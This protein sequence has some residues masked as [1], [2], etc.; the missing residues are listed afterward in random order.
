MRAAFVTL[1]ALAGAPPA[2]AAPDFDITPD[3]REERAERGEDFS[4]EIR[5]RECAKEGVQVQVLGSGGP[6]LD[7]GQA[8]SGHLVW[9][10][11]RARILVDLGGGVPV[12]YEEAGAVLRDLDAFVF[13][14]L[15]ADH[16]AG[17]P[18][19]VKGARFEER[20]DDLP[21][22]G[23]TGNQLFPGT[24]DWVNR[25][26]GARGAYPYLSDFLTSLSSAGFKIAP[27]D[28]PAEGRRIWS[29]HYAGGSKLSAV[30]VHHGPV[31]A[32]AWRVDTRTVSVTFTGDAN[33]QKGTIARLADGSDILVAHHAIPEQARGTAREL[34]MRPSQIG[35]IAQQAGV[36]MV[37]LSHRMSRTRG[38]ESQTR[39]AIA[40]HFGGPVVFGDDLECWGL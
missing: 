6:E 22:Y 28:V 29:Q 32:L 35:R 34:H 5:G 24:V 39:Q 36:D 38:R 17:F 9:V 12:R 23:P 18:A 13:T 25:M 15:H 37:V 33:N 11:G 19:L 26:I 2:P 4:V 3:R 20:A 21:V 8:S 14:H 16:T 27:H 1:L 40:E 10:D 30:P 31:P 7:D